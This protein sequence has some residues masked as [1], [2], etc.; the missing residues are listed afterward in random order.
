MQPPRRSLRSA[1]WSA[2][3]ARA[4]T[5]TKVGRTLAAY[6]PRANGLPD[7]GEVVWA[8]VAF[9]EDADRG[10]DRPV[11]VVGRAGRSSVYA[12]MLTS[13]SRRAADPQWVPLGAGP[14]DPLERPSWVRLDRV[15][16]LPNRAMRRE[17]AALS[18]AVF[19]SLRDRLRAGYGWV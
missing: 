16:W 3:A 2:R 19:A 9:E 11:V 14:W 1:P 18:P 5:A 17:G 7:P 15:L 13:Q 4:V 12:L 10:K 8:F 6:R